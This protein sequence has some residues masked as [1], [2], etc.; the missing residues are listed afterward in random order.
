MT[1]KAQRAE[2]MRRLCKHMSE[3]SLELYDSHGYSSGWFESTVNMM[4]QH[5]SKAEQAQ[6]L[7]HMLMGV[8]RMDDRLAYKNT[9]S[10][11]A[12]YKDTYE[13]TA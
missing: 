11:Y 10:L 12:A 6:Y 1:T 13:T 2:T 3:A 8:D 7:R 4:F 5:L 9:V